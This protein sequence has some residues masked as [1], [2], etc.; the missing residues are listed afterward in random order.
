MTIRRLRR[1]T[2]ISLIACV[3]V[4]FAALLAGCS[5]TTPQSSVAAVSASEA[6]L[7]AAGRT[8]LVCYAVPRCATAAPKVQIRTAYDQAYTAATT[9]QA[10]ADAGGTPDLTA[11]TAA[12]SAL[13][14]LVAQLQLPPTT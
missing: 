5:S 12:M 7:A 10:I 1:I 4:P 11:T 2:S 6:A 14:A 8:I 13:Q 3:W 9:A